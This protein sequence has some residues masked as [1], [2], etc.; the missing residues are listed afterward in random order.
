MLGSLFLKLQAYNLTSTTLLK[1]EPP[2][3]MLYCEF[4]ENFS[5]QVFLEYIQ[6]AASLCYQEYQEYQLEPHE[7]SHEITLILMLD[8]SKTE[9]MTV[10]SSPSEVF[11][12]KGALKICSKFTGEHSCRS[13]IFNKVAFI[14]YDWVNQVLY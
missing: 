14:S 1:Q 9:E 7:D 3:Q 5:E 10:R 8:R 2:V 11:L 6:A 4:C 13:V 12:G